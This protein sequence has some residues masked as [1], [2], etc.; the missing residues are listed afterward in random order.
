MSSVVR[1]V[2]LAKAVVAGR[3]VNTDGHV[4]DSRGGTFDDAEAVRGPVQREH[5][6]VDRGDPGER[7]W[8]LAEQATKLGH[9]GPLAFDV[10]EYTG[11]VVQH[12]ADEPEG[13]RVAEHERAKAHALHRPG[14]PHS[15]ALGELTYLA[16]QR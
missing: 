1:V 10:D 16:H 6:P 4:W 13:Y 7:R 2:H 12:E 8:V 15:P 5:G 3:A 11:G 9:A 14:H